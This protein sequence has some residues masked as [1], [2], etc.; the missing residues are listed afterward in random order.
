MLKVVL[1]DILVN[2]K[3]NWVSILFSMIWFILISISLTSISYSLNAVPAKEKE[4]IGKIV[5]DEVALNEKILRQIIPL[6]NGMAINFLFS[7]TNK[8]PLRLSKGMFVCAAGEKEKMKYIYLQ[9]AVK[10]IF[11]FIFIFATSYFFTG[12]FFPSQGL[13]LNIVQLTLWFFI[14]LNVNL[15]IGIGEQ[16]LRKKDIEDY[17][18]YSKEEEIVNY[19]WV[20]LLILEAVIFYTL[21]ILNVPLNLLG[22]IGWTVAFI[23]NAYISYRC[24][25]PILKK[26][27]SYEDVYRQIPERKE[28]Y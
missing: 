26:S 18:I 28:G 14:I 24:V 2:L 16:G 8:I 9:L 3:K 27:L 21:Y 12:R 17:I 23:I 7:I 1:N 22:V 11:T 5:L 10:I 6:I 25:S 4:A 13:G 19:Y 20:C 15:K